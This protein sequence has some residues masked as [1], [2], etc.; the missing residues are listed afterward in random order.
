MRTTTKIKSDQ[1]CGHS[2]CACST[3]IHEGLTFGHGRLDEYGY[4]EFPCAICARVWD[5]KREQTKE[6]VRVEEGPDYDVDTAEWL[7]M[8]AWPFPDQDV[9]QLMKSWQESYEH[10]SEKERQF[11]DEWECLFT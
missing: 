6:E 8:D 5:E 10:R 2:D 7:N 11:E 4:W 9:E 3:G 1:P